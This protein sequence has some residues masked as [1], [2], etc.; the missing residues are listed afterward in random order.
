MAPKWL[1][2][3]SPSFNVHQIFLEHL[4]CT[5]IYLVLL[6]MSVNQMTK[7]CPSRSSHSDWK[8]WRDKTSN[9]ERH[10]T[11]DG[12]K[13][14]GER[15]RRGSQEED[16]CRCFT[17]T[18]IFGQ[19]PAG[20]EGVRH[21]DPWGETRVD[22]L[23]WAGSPRGETQERG[24]G[25][26]CGKVV[27]CSTG[28]LGRLVETQ[29]VHRLLEFLIQKCV[30]LARLPVSLVQGRHFWDPARLLKDSGCHS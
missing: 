20:E 9:M 13:C 29:V 8:T 14:Y 6:A 27:L 4:L 16:G 1:N 11:W 12:D 30:L 28:S 19:R 15:L 24:G 17:R 5:D 3:T 22:G 26:S 23:M 2:R 10:S 25:S 21:T 18:L 7:I